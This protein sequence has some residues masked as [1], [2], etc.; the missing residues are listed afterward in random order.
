MVLWMWVLNRIEVS[1]ASVS[2][3]M[4]S[5]FGVI[6]STIMLHERLG[7]VQLLGGLVV[8]VATLFATEFDHRTTQRKRDSLSDETRS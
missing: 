4:L 7:L 8:V 3:Y 6:L 2:V 1:Q 5:I